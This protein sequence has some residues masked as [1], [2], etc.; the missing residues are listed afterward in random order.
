MVS[1]KVEADVAVL[2]GQARIGGGVT[3]AAGPNGQ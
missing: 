1:A 3:V 2:A